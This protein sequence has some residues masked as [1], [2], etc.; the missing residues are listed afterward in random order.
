MTA[1]REATIPRDGIGKA[2]EATPPIRVAT[3]SINDARFIKDLDRLKD[4]R[5]FL[6]QEAIPTTAEE[7]AALSLGDLNLLQWDV[8]GRVPTLEE[9]SELEKGTRTL[10]RPLSDAQRRR[11]LVGEIPPWVSTLAIWLAVAAI[12]ALIAAILV[13]WQNISWLKSINSG[14]R[15]L[16]VYLIWL[17][18]LGAIGSIAFIG[19]NALSVQHDVTFDLGNRTLLLLRIALGALFGLVLTLPFGYSGFSDFVYDI[20][21]YDPGNSSPARLTS[22]LAARAA[23]LLLPFILGF[24]TSLVIVILNKLMDGAQALFGGTGKHDGQEPSTAPSSSSAS[25][26]RN[27]S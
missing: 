2:E 18:S 1:S 16:P 3:T 9:W 25:T 4:L 26:R 8:K 10:F 22:G 5:T 20:N 15:V 12:V 23:L 14:A 6:I 19:M 27:Q 24:S 17:M 13:P 21:Q 11:F 7:S